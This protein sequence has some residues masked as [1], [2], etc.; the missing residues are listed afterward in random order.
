MQKIEL[1]ESLL[2]EA[3]ELPRLDRASLD[4]LK[5]RS[6][7]LIRRIFGEASP[8]LGDL[9]HVIFHPTFAPADA[10]DGCAVA[11][12]HLMTGTGPL[13]ELRSS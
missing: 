1:L 13:A 2:S 10:S 4:A 8:Y 7:M 5:R 12:C 11:L 9:S 6:E 3:S